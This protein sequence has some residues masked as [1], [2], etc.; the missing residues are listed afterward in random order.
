MVRSQ[1]RTVRQRSHRVDIAEH[2]VSRGVRD[3]G[4]RAVATVALS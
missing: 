1:R 4:A 2:G 3:R